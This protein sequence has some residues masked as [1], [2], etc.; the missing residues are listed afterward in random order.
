MKTALVLSGGSIKGAFQA[1]AIEEVLKNSIIPTAIYGISVGSLNGAFLVDR[2]GQAVAGNR[3]VDWP[4]IGEELVKFWEDNIKS[5]AAIGKKRGKVELGWDVIWGRF[6][7]L[8]DTK[9]LRDLVDKTLDL[10]N[11][12]RSPVMFKAGSVNLADGSLVQADISYPDFIDYIVASTV[13]PI[14]MP[15][16][17]VANQPLVD[18]GNR[19]VAP[20]KAAIDDGA[21]EVICVVCQSKHLPGS[22]L[23]KGSL[24]GLA[25][26]VMEIATNE[27]VNNDLEWAEY[28]NWFC[29]DDGSKITS[30]PFAGSRRIKLTVIRPATTPDISLTDFKRSDIMQMID[31]GRY[32]ARVELAKR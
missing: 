2:S 21:E 18:G 32:A 3:K 20:L 27:I 30:G 17:W 6:D 26:R 24:A 22:D 12:R 31:T 29:P 1:G 9:N 23:K 5:F 7:G 25:E 15:I 4:K 8:I 16:S 10:D 28:I 11:L 14:V 13:I 19:D